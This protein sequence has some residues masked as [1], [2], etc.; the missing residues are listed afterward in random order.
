MKTIK[1]VSEIARISIRTL[2]YYDEIGL[3]KPAQLTKAGY[4]LYDDS[5]LAKLQ[6][7]LFFK[8][9]DCPLRD[10]RKI[11]DDPDYDR[12]QLLIAQKALLEKKRNRL[13]G[14]IEL[15]TDVIGGI[16]TMSFEAFNN[17]DIQKMV[18][19]SLECMSPE[20]LE[21]QIKKHG[22]IEKYR[23]ILTNGFSGNE[24][25]MAQ[26]INWYGG[27]EKAVEA[28]LQSTGNMEEFKQEQDATAEVYAQFKT[29][30]ETD[31]IDLAYDAVSRLAKCY[32]EMFKLDNA[33]NIL[34]DLAKEYL[35]LEKLAE[36]TDMQYG[37][38][39]S[40]YIAHTI[41][42]CYGV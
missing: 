40:E 13:N 32:K 16:N 21:E 39:I 34:L 4:R 38:G 31:N 42:N 8:E 9:L 33:R 11:L 27:K 14:I 37:S 28:V 17:E 3:L 24:K 36:I 30:K 10:I 1:E 41:N 5:A 35:Q 25:S 19:H 20:L 18:D 15:I 22:S 2:R 7:I 23:E 26:V 12:E 6:L 29:A